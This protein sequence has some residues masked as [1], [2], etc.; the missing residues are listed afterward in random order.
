MLE[1]CEEV[2]EKYKPHGILKRITNFDSEEFQQ[3]F[4]CWEFRSYQFSIDFGEDDLIYVLGELSIE[5]WEL[6]CPLAGENGY[7]LRMIKWFDDTMI[8]YIDEDEEGGL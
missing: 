3:L 6:V 4:E 2:V 5:G 1:P 7:L 8:D